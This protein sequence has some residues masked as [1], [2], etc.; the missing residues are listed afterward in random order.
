MNIKKEIIYHN[1]SIEKAAL[2]VEIT[3]QAL[4]IIIKKPI[5]LFSI[6]DCRKLKMLIPVEKYKTL[7]DCITK[8]I[9]KYLLGGE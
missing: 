5:H 8:E 9:K 4:Y 7:I 6:E 3:K 1:N 2:K